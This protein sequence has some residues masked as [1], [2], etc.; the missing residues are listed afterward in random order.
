MSKGKGTG[1]A[2]ERFSSANS[3]PRFKRVPRKVRKIEIDDRFEGMFKEA[4]FKLNYSQDK[5]GRPISS[6]ASED[7]RRYYRLEE[8]EE[9]GGLTGAELVCRSRGEIE[10]ESSSSSDSEQEDAGN[11]REELIHAWAELDQSVATTDVS[12][13]RLAVCNMDW[14][15]VTAIDIFKLLSSLT[16]DNGHILS[17]RVFP[18]KYGASRIKIEEAVGPEELLGGGDNEGSGEED[19]NEALQ[20]ERLRKYQLN[21]LL[22]Y[23][24]I[25]GKYIRTIQL[26]TLVTNNTT[27]IAILKG[28]IYSYFESVEIS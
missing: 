19:Q 24:A 9:G 18:S 20:T 5:R 10:I 23:Y 28:A 12:T 27:L 17:V 13:S 22:Y 15:R 2:D 3:D 11:V 8:G 16:S 26:Q 21:R 25:V 6:T 14:D 4:R 1:L 7:L